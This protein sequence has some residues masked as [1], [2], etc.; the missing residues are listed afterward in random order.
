[1]DKEELK[2]AKV[3]I[4]ISQEIYHKLIAKRES[5]GSYESHKDI[6]EKLI[7]KAEKFDAIGVH[8]EEENK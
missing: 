2:R 6:I 3:G 8:R 5:K 1:M 4:G 7:F